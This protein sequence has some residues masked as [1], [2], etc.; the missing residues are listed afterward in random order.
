MAKSARKRDR[1]ML[2]SI[3]ERVAESAS[4]RFGGEL[5]PELLAVLDSKHNPLIQTAE[6]FTASLNR[7]LNQEAQSESHPKNE[8]ASHLL[9]AV[10]MPDGPNGLEAI[11]DMTGLIAL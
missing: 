4:G 8:F 3:P 10:Q 6:L 1:L 2:A 5:Y 7:K 11:D 9:D